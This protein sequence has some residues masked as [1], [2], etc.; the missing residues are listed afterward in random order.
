[1]SELDKELQ[2]VKSD[3]PAD[4]NNVNDPSTSAAGGSNQPGS[5]KEHEQ[6]VENLRREYERKLA[7]SEEKFLSKLQEMERKLESK[8]TPTSQPAVKNSVADYSTQE[9]ETMLGNVQLTPV[10]RTVIQNE[11]TARTVRDVTKQTIQAE[12]YRTRIEQAKQAVRQQ[13]LSEY[14]ALSDADSE[15]YSAVDAELSNRRAMFGEQPTDVLDAANAVARRMG[16]APVIRRS[17]NSDIAG[18]GNNGPGGNGGNRR[19]KYELSD[20]RRA[21]IAE[22]LSEALPSGKKFDDKKLKERSRAYAE[23]THL[24]GIGGGN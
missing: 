17:V 24:Y 18:G 23:N 3:P 19:L 14:P 16:V 4:N 20:E 2:G 6:R 9:L 10:Q 5:D 7:K 8:L 11:L 15:F 21:A 1:M 22:R 13:A 12:T